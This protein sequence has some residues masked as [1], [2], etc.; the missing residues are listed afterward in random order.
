VHEQLKSEQYRPRPVLRWYIA[1]PGNSEKRPLGI[2]V[3]FAGFFDNI[4]QNI[5]LDLVTRR[6]ADRRILKLI[7]MWLEAG[8]MK[9]GKYI[10]S[11]GLGTSQGSVMTPRTQMVTLNLFA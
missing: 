4:P 10:A 8:V 1:K 9:E 6:I 2:P 3:N 11:N 7:R 5:L